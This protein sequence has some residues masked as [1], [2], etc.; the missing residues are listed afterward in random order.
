MR[1]L[2]TND[3][4]IESTG[5]RVLARRLARVGEVT[6]FAPSYDL[7]GSSAAIG[8]IGDGLP[9]VI[10]VDTDDL[11]DVRAAYHLDGPPA[12]AALL[13]CSGLFDGGPDIVISGVNRGWNV[14]RAV[15]FSG[16]V[17]AC[18]V[19]HGFGLPAIAV[20]QVAAGP[21][22]EQWWDTAADVVADSVAGVIAAPR[23]LNVNVPNRRRS[24]IVGT[25][26]TALANRLPYALHSPTLT[27]IGNGRYATRVEH[28]GPIERPEGSDVVAVERGYVSVTV[29][30]PTHAI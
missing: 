16:T 26:E 21:D 30:S 14:G 24:D 15:H 22:D 2:V 29:L 11:G 17:G 12:L 4:G 18:V 5:L 6:V 9:D 25:L 10:E 20:S 3:D 28:A 8:P 1:I 7:S 13:A 19:A 27:P 23:V